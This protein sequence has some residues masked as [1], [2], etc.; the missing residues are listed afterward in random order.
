MATPAPATAPPGQSKPTWRYVERALSALTGIVAVIYAAGFLVVSIH[1]GHYG[2]ILFEFLRARIFAAGL[3][4]TIFIA[5][6]SIAAS[7]T[8]ALFGLRLGTLTPVTKVEASKMMYANVC[9]G[10]GF[11]CFAYVLAGAFG[12]LFRSDY[13][14]PT[15]SARW[16]FVLGLSVLSSI[17]SFRLLINKRPL[18]TT[19]INLIALAGIALSIAKIQSRTLFM[20]SLWFYIAG[21]VFILL[22]HFVKDQQTV[23]SIDWERWVASAL[24]GIVFFA[25]SIYG[26]IKP[27]WGGG[28]VSPVKVHFLHKTAFSDSLD[29]AAF[30]IDET[31]RGFYLTHSPDDTRASFIPREAIGSIDFQSE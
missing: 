20:V 28:S 5:V 8:F 14:N 26:R 29:A 21:L 27:S 22:Y 3:L 10:C 19:I 4:L 31:E 17:L 15:S 18:L 23:R 24:L 1:H 7:R 30:L 16:W 25:N 13:W 12:L 6:P 11:F 2:V 9:V